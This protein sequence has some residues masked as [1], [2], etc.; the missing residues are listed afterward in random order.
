MLTFDKVVSEVSDVVLCDSL[1]AR[2]VPGSGPDIDEDDMAPFLSFARRAAAGEKNFF[3][4]QLYP[5]EEKY[6]DNTTTLTAS[7]L[8][9]H[10][11]AKKVPCTQKTCLDTPILYRADMNGF[12][13]YGYA[14]MT[15]QDH[16]NHLYGM[17]DL[18]RQT[19]LNDVKK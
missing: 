15:N 8:I 6:R 2:H 9:E 19:S 17:H 16:F 3:F 11:G 4:S 7:Y 13:I 14:G 1:Y 12:H 10:V 5:P 18:L